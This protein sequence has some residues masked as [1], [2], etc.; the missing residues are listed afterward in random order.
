MNKMHNSVPVQDFGR[1]DDVYLFLMACCLNFIFLA[2]LHDL[3]TEEN[4]NYISQP[5]KD[6][7]NLER[8]V[9]NLDMAKQEGR[10]ALPLQ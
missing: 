9:A 3:A 5:W 6:F 7:K 1:S 2:V 8:R 4:R 10:G